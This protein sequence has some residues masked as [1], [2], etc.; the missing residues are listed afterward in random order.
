MRQPPMAFLIALFAGTLG[1]SAWLLFVLQPMVA[2]M[3]LPLLG[4]SP[5]VWNVSLV[6][7]QG[8]LFLGYVFAHALAR[9]KSIRIQG[10][11]LITVWLIA[12]IFLPIRISESAGLS[13]LDR[14]NPFLWELGT[15]I[16]RV[17]LPF[18]AL[19]VVAPLLQNWFSRTG[20]PAAA[21]PYFLYIASN[22]GSLAA[23]LIYPIGIEPFLPLS[24]QSNFWSLVFCFLGG[25]IAACALLSM[26]FALNF[27]P[28]RD[29][30]VEPER[31]ITPARLKRQARWVFWAF[32][33]SSLSL[34][35]TTYLVQEIA[36]VP[37]LWILPLSVYLLTFILA[38]RKKGIPLPNLERIF[39]I[40]AVVIALTL[41]VRARDPAW[42]LLPLHLAFLFLVGLLAHGRLAADRPPAG[43]LTRFFLY[44]SLGGL[45][46]GLFNGLLAPL[47]FSSNIE[48]TLILIGSALLGFPRAR[49]RDNERSRAAMV[50]GGIGALTVLAAVV[51]SR[52]V[53]E[54]FYRNILAFG[55]PLIAVCVLA[56]QR[57]RFAVA[58]ACVFIITRWTIQTEGETV[59]A[60]R[61]FFGT[62]R[63]TLDR[64]HRM[65]RLHHGNTIH[66]MQFIDPL[67]ENEP[68]AYYHRTGP[69]RQIVTAQGRHSAGS[70]IAVIG[71]GTGSLAAYARPGQLWTFYEIDPLVVAVARNTNYFTYLA[72]CAG[73]TR[74]ILGDARLRIR[75]A[76]PHSYRLIMVDAFSSDL[77]PLHLMT[78]EA[79]DLYLSKLTAGGLLGFHIS[80]RH[81]DFLPVL[82]NLATA[83]GL[84][85]WS[86][87]DS[88]LDEVAESEGK[89]AS[90]WVVLTRQEGNFGNLG[91]FPG[92]KEVNGTDPAR[93]WTDDY[94]NIWRILK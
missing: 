63:V 45:F 8:T 21:D 5:S 44:L 25:L 20:H 9:S 53:A 24:G 81:L 92:R 88:L 19:S 86:F 56:R 70:Q 60:R 66:G 58:L 14:T 12:V 90:H 71:L 28:K 79:L 1:L 40:A 31:K 75:E 38:F 6:F 7:F 43:E 47:L 3:L 67:R 74:I 59:F 61:N 77:P 52:F 91:K 27:R 87:D 13:P 78:A 48:Y 69:A 65:R 94:S 29:L 18:L 30:R 34:S 80:N 51:S 17:G 26:R 16:F 2:K 85:C 15:L 36:S 39:P 37:L 32:I 4:G 10:A 41:L 57:F 49:N 72:R 89:M 50:T 11:I 83:A 93:S 33:P 55:F 84:H 22:V 76:T 68:L 73:A 82:A 46:G 64:Q 54:G 42:L 35:V 62:L 23:L